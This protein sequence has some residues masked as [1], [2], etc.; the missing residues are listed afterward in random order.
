MKRIQL[1]LNILAVFVDYIMLILAGLVAY[2]VRY[3]ESVQSVR[4]V[5]FDLPL[6]QYLQLLLLTALIWIILFAFVGLYTTTYRWRLIQELKQILLGISLGFVAVITFIFG[7]RELFSSRFII[8]AA[9]LLAILF[10]SVGRILLRYLRRLLLQ[11]NKGITS[12]ILI[13]GDKTAQ[14]LE[15]T[16]A[17]E[18]VWGFRIVAHEPVFS[19]EKINKILK[20]KNIDEIF[21][22]DPNIDRA[23]RVEVYEY[24]IKNHLGFRYS[25]DMFDAQSHNIVVQTFAGVPIIEI[26]KTRLDGWGRVNKRIFDFL[27]GLFLFIIALPIMLLTALAIRIESPGQIIY[28]NKRVGKDGQEFILYKFRRLQQKFCTDDKSLV[29]LE[30]EKK[31]IS[32]QNFRQGG[33]Y[34]IINDPRSTKVGRFI[35]RYS[36]DELP[37]LYNV[38]IGNMS[39]VGP[40]PHQARE[41]DNF[42][43]NHERVQ[44]LKPGITGLAQISGRS[45]LITI[46]ELR[47]DIYYIEN[48]SLQLDINIL[49]RTP[50]VI[51]KRHKS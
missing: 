26:R 37:Q 40:R 4:P 45:D 9:V 21:L 34:K 24:C 50:F 29:A 31:L 30:F 10:V 20:Q 7:S 51:L 36:I 46:E 5:I 35:E 17:T 19:I 44:S 27:V 11:K 6:E 12:V 3:A 48:W 22:A 14:I 15:T 16:F 1:F 8:L 33:L 2:A 18:P 28:K 41:V 42:P 32:E 43:K 47:L 23:T 39:L 38:I 49:L 13:G 25:A